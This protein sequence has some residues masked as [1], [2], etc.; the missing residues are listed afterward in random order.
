MQ[1]KVLNCKLMARIVR[2]VVLNIN[3]HEHYSVHPCWATSERK[4][5]KIQ[6]H[7]TRTHQIL[8]EV[9]D[10]KLCNV[11]HI[12]IYWDEINTYIP[13][14]ETIQLQQ[15]DKH[16][17]FIH[18]GVCVWGFFGCR[19]CHL[20]NEPDTILGPFCLMAKHV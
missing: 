8:D 9:S 18:F 7:Q 5:L 13:G 10:I 11:S 4:N 14:N 3:S 2:L 20:V 12:P 6:Q 15:C 17:K 16:N 19:I 1:K